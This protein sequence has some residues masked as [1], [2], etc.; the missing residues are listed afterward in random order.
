MILVVLGCTFY[1]RAGL[2]RGTICRLSQDK[3]IYKTMER[4]SGTLEGLDRPWPGDGF[5]R[6][7]LYLMLTTHPCTHR[8][9]HWVPHKKP[10]AALACRS[11]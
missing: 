8:P 9:T 5:V 10:A 7:R 4:D 3:D 11:G 1:C 6:W 2:L